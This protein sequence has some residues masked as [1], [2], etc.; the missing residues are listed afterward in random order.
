MTMKPAISDENIRKMSNDISDKLLSDLSIRDRKHFDIFIDEYLS[1][2][3]KYDFKNAPQRNAFI[4]VTALMISEV[5]K[6]LVCAAVVEVSKYYFKELY[7][8]VSSMNRNEMVTTLSSRFSEEAMQMGL[9]P[10]QA[11]ELSKKFSEI[12]IVNPFLNP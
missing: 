1:S 5:P 3:E 2:P 4:D 9:N 6:A 8:R 11:K 7:H 10:S 12:L